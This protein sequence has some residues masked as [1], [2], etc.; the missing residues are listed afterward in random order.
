MNSSRRVTTTRSVLVSSTEERG[1]RRRLGGRRV[2]SCTMC[3]VATSKRHSKWRS[4]WRDSMGSC[5]DLLV[6]I[7]IMAKTSLMLALSHGHASFPSLLQL[8]LLLDSEQE[9]IQTRHL[10]AS[11]HV[12]PVHLLNFFLHGS[13]LSVQVPSFILIA[14]CTH[15]Y[16]SF[17]LVS[18]QSS[19]NNTALS[20]LA[21]SCF[22][23]VDLT[24]QLWDTD[25]LI[26]FQRTKN[27]ITNHVDIFVAPSELSGNVWNYLEIIFA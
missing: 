12:A 11:R 18:L 13:H 21:S 4:G 7:I 14:F 1:R 24:P 8:I 15:F 25:S 22:V 9:R 19:K 27:Q 20:A 10:F 16:F 26:L 3:R 6:I 2:R 17:F 5:R 23:S